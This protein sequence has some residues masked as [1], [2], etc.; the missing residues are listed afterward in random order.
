[1]MPAHAAPWAA[2][3]VAV[4]LLDVVRRCLLAALR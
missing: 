2:P 4:A 1:M 3:Q